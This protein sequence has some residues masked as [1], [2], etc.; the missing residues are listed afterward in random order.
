MLLPSLQ[1]LST[2]E[3]QATFTKMSKYSFRYFT[4]GTQIF[5]KSDVK[6]IKLCLI[7]FDIR[8]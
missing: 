2:F 5:L 3:N 1:L 4:L 7:T 8:N 6:M